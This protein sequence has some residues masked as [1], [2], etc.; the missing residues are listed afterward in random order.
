MV[1]SH[2]HVLGEAAVKKIYIHWREESSVAIAYL[3][4]YKEGKEDV[5]RDGA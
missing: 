5:E 3:A 2:Q 1:T 4:I